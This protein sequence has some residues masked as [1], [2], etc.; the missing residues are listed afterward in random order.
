[1]RCF[2]LFKREGETDAFR[3]KKHTKHLFAGFV[4][5]SVHFFNILYVNIAYNSFT[6]EHHGHEHQQPKRYLAAAVEK[7][8]YNDF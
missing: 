8:Y 1:M 4:L 6:H 2:L 3:G 7:A 5:S